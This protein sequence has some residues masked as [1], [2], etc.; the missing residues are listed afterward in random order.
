M[1]SHLFRKCMF[2]EATSNMELF[3]E[4]SS[5]RRL[6]LDCAA[7]VEENCIESD[8]P[9]DGTRWGT[10]FMGM[11]WWMWE[12]RNELVFKNNYIPPTKVAEK[13]KQMVDEA[14]KFT[15]REML[16]I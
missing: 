14:T 5:Y 12:E 7:W 3:T 4:I 10:K 15:T 2:P 13:V 6:G 8:R 11:L 9:E 1:L 16:L